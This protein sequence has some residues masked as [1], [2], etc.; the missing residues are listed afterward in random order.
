MGGADGNDGN[1]GG[2]AKAY[3]LKDNLSVGIFLGEGEGQKTIVVTDPSDLDVP[4]GVQAISLK[5]PD[6]QVCVYSMS[7]PDAKFDEKLTEMVVDR[8][9]IDAVR[10]I[11]NTR[12]AVIGEHTHQMYRP[13]NTTPRTHA[14]MIPLGDLEKDFDILCPGSTPPVNKPARGAG[15]YGHP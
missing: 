6:S 11:E 10:D 1:G 5:R 12:L 7:H 13:G 8:R 2:L 3:V 15:R 14:V 4:S 9:A